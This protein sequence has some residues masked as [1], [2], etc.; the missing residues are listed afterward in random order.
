MKN[1]KS[2][3]KVIAAAVSV[4]AVVGWLG[5]QFWSA[6]QPQ[7]IRLQGQVEAQ[8]YNISSKVPGR[9]GQV[10]A[11]KGDMV[12]KGDLIL[13]FRPEIEAKLEQ[14]RAGEQAA[15][16]M[17]QRRKQ[18]LEY[19][20]LPQHKISGKKPSGSALMQ[21]TY[22]RVDNL[23]KE[24]VMA[25]QKRDEAYTQWQAARYTEQAAYQMYTMAKEGAR[26][27]TKRA[28]A[29]SPMAA[30]AVAEV[31]A[32]AADTQISSCWR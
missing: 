19:R 5:Y 3:M 10:M 32:Y 7:P 31:E 25:E 26:V 29:E 9:I 28:A 1:G 6:Y 14:A 18:V 11:R 8:H 16:A 30:G 12:E 21:K 4:T 22:R 23:Y 15:D 13:I 17:S 20:K 2:S 27:E 24:G